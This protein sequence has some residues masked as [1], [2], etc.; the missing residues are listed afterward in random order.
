MLYDV[1]K[2]QTDRTLAAV[3]DK[4]ARCHDV[5]RLNQII[6]YAIRALDEIGKETEEMV[7]ELEALA[8]DD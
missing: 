4:L 6:K 1:K 5:Y 2:N 3:L 8:Y 7:C